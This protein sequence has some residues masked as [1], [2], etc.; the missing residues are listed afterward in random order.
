[1]FLRQGY[2]TLDLVSN[3]KNKTSRTVSHLAIN[4]PFHN[5]VS[6][7]A[8]ILICYGGTGQSIIFT[9]TK[10]EANQLLQSEKIKNQIEVMHGDIAQNQREVILKRFKDKK[11]QV[12]VATDVA[13]RG[14]DI[15][16][17][18]LVIQVEPPKDPETYI[19]RSGRTAR[20]G[21]SGTCITFFT[22][23]HKLMLA[24]I[25]QKA[26]I[27]MQKIGVPQPEQ[28]IKASSLGIVEQLK[29]VNEKV[30]PL[31]GEAAE[32]LITKMDGDVKKALC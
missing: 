10:N 17:V 1:M 3:L 25:E 4:V 7:L 5:R 20:A 9:S 14:L 6:A 24:H 31:F 8:D 15:P 21:R 22:N 30:I 28:V 27:T 18:D 19:H 26:G 12:L 16:S 2:Q 32:H 13:S 29:E 11:F 23:K